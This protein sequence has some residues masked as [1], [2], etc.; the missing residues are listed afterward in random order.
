MMPSSGAKSPHLLVFH[1]F[2]NVDLRVCSHHS[3]APTAY[4][5]SSGPPPCRCS[6]YPALCGF[7]NANRGPFPNIQHGLFQISLIVVVIN[8][9]IRC[10]DITLLVGLLEEE[11]IRFIEQTCRVASR[12]S[13]ASV[14]N[15][16]LND[17]NDRHRGSRD[18]ET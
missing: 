9:Q 14:N 8:L 10:R 4:V 3:V 6:E 12:Q 15:T 17:Y 1:D 16:A 2:S 11:W 13:D 18:A 5:S 7:V